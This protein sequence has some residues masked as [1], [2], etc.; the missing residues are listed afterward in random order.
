MDLER[1]TLRSGSR[2][3]ARNLPHYTSYSELMQHHH[4]LLDHTPVKAQ[5]IARIAGVRGASLSQTTV[6]FRF[7]SPLIESTLLDIF[8]DLFHE[9]EENSSDGFEVVTT[10]NAVL[11]SEDASTFSLFYGLDHRAT[12]QS[13]AA[14]E[15][16][17]GDPIIIKNIL[18][19]NKIPTYFDADELI[20]SHSN[21][22]D[23]SNVRVH[24]FVNIVYLIYRFVAV[25]INRRPNQHGRSKR[26]KSTS[27]SKLSKSK[28]AT[29]RSTATR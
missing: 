24:S 6:R 23:N 5:R 26:K 14:P 20:R 21:A 27:H 17:Y 28:S 18:D 9:H 25:N 8:I 2:F 29:R 15:L 13:G 1:G 11:S 22:F 12:N 10:F 19:V 3:A 7:D 16:S 4:K